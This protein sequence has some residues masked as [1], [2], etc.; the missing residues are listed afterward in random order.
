LFQNEEVLE[1]IS[2][3]YISR[4]LQTILERLKAK[5]THEEFLN[6]LNSI[7]LSGCSIL[8]YVAALNYHE[9]VSIFYQFGA[10]L[11]LKT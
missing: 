1:T 3:E 7:D 5:N 4:L 9:L 11:S 10:N 2:R 6:L 8:H